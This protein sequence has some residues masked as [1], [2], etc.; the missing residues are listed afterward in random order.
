M[1]QSWIRS[2]AEVFGST[3]DGYSYGSGYLVNGRALLTAAHVVANLELV[4][5]RLAGS[6]TVL[7]GSVAWKDEDADLALV[8]MDVEVEGVHAA[9][10]CALSFETS[11]RVPFVA[12]G[13]PRLGQQG[14]TRESVH[15]EGALHLGSNLKGGR[16]DVQVTSHDPGDGQGETWVGLSGAAIFVDD[17]GL[18]GVITGRRSIAGSSALEGTS[19]SAVA[20]D[21]SFLLALDQLGLSRPREKRV[22]H[23]AALAILSRLEFMDSLPRLRRSLLHDNVVFVEPPGDH[24]AS[25]SNIVS[26]LV[27]EQGKRAV[28]LHG[29]GGTGKTRTCLEVMILA[30]RLGWSA[31]YIQP[32]VARVTEHDILTAIERANGPVLICLDYVNELTELSIVSLLSRIDAAGYRDVYVLASARPGWYATHRQSLAGAIIRVDLELAIE[33]QKL[34]L[35]TNIVSIAPFATKKFGVARVSTLCGHR[36]A[37]ALLIATEIERRV[38][39]GES[40]Q[41]LQ[42]RRTGDLLSW[43]TKRLAEDELQRSDPTSAWDSS[44]PGEPLVASAALLLCTPRSADDLA[45]FTSTLPLR[46]QAQFNSALSVLEHLG[47]I[48]TIDGELK[49]VHDV[50]VDMIL[51]SALRDPFGDFSEHQVLTTV[52]QPL[53]S[54]ARSLGRAMQ[55]MNRYA[56]DFTSDRDIEGFRALVGGWI[57]AHAEEL[58]RAFS[59]D[60]DVGGYAL[61]GILSGL[62]FKEVLADGISKITEPWL[63][64]FGTLPEAKHVLYTWLKAGATESFPLLQERSRRWVEENGALPTASFVLSGILREPKLNSPDAKLWFDLA[65]RYLE[66]FPTQPNSGFVLAPMFNRID[67]EGEPLA[68]AYSSASAWLA[69]NRGIHAGFVLNAILVRREINLETDTIFAHALSW[70]QENKSI[71][72]ASYVLEGM[73]GRSDLDLAL[74]TVTVKFARDWLASFGDIEVAEFVYKPA[75]LRLDLDP[76]VT[77]EFVDLARKWIKSHGETEVSGYV[78]GALLATLEAQGLLT[79]ADFE[80]AAAWFALHPNSVM[81]GRIIESLL[82]PQFGPLRNT[83]SVSQWLWANRSRQDF[84]FVL[85]R[86]LASRDTAPFDVVFIALHWCFENPDDEDFKW[87]LSAALRHVRDHSGLSNMA[88]TIVERYFE[89]ATSDLPKENTDGSVDVMLA[90]LCQA[91]RTGIVAAR[92]DYLLETWINS[93]AAYSSPVPVPAQASEYVSRLAALIRSDELLDRRGANWGRLQS[94]AQS[95]PASDAR[96]RALELLEAE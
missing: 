66:I 70:L 13:F 69:T 1:Q 37:I 6:A 27:S 75:L 95:W 56:L 7:T 11:E 86:L 16:L 80:S 40:S 8:A 85:K 82:S 21:G 63:D 4:S 72:Q 17:A 10:L 2:L 93:S 77:L 96:R 50:V 43:L 87:R 89:S 22:E 74:L 88:M 48:E 54:N 19:L 68:R 79:E 94:F 25:P 36:P 14:T 60:P 23:T 91:M 49:C 12:T 9:H 44:W 84:R 35:S 15:V 73:L 39:Q 41:V 90:A 76:G 52:L 71:E 30:E 67:L 42:A 34:I 45:A 47:W 78:H 31:L 92:A 3:A 24:P 62:F 33:F 28:L 38:E 83:L 32:G 64:L 20:E 26:S 51:D 59:V 29:P 61:G 81:T 5:V 46:D 57:T 18:V 53:L 58:G 55:H 65:L